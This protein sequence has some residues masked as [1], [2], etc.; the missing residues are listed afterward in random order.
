ML[1]IYA[2]LALLLSSL[3]NESEPPAPGTPQHAH[4]RTDHCRYP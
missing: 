3:T 1:L 2:L 4:G